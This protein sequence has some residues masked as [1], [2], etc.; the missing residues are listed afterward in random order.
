MYIYLLFEQDSL[1]IQPNLLHERKR[2]NQMK[3]K[4]A[5]QSSLRILH[6]HRS[7]IPQLET[8]IL[9]LHLLSLLYEQTARAKAARYTI[10]QAGAINAEALADLATFHH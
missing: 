10:V 3:N 5:L 6:L 2:I 4:S 8:G 9:R 1:Y 7:L